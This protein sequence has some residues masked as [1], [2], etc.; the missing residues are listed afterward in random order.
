MD[1]V[2]YTQ[3]ELKRII[4]RFVAD[5]NRGISVRLFCELA[6][7]T[8]THLREVFIHERETLTPIMQQRVAR[9]YERF[10]RGEVKTMT[11]SNK[12][13]VEYRDVPQPKLKRETRLVLTPDGFQIRAAVRLRGDY[14]QPTLE[15]QL[16][17]CK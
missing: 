11:Q 17:R 6:G 14:D 3:Q 16:R 10:K 15:E 8:T 12:R 4:K 2:R 1:E 5:K 7:L 13:W 9:A